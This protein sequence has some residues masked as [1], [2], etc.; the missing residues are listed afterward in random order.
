MAD[1]IAQK[2]IKQTEDMEAIQTRLDE[3]GSG[4]NRATKEA[5]TVMRGIA[6][7]KLMIVIICCI[8]AIALALVVGRIIWYV[9]DKENARFKISYAGSAG[10]K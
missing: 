4:L 1:G 9:V 5:N 8:I 10:S 7:D 2:L 6:T 3:L